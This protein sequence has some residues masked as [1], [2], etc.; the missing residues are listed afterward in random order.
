MRRPNRPLAL[1][2]CVA[3]DKPELSRMSV[4]VLRVVYARLSTLRSTRRDQ[5]VWVSCTSRTGLVQPP[6]ADFEEDPIRA[7]Y[8]VELC[9]LFEFLVKQLL[10]NVVLFCL[11]DGVVYYQRNE[12]I[13]DMGYVL[14]KLL[15]ISEDQD[16]Q[17]TVKILLTSPTRTNCVRKPFPDER[18]LSMALMAHVDTAPSATRLERQLRES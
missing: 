17:A 7:G 16:M 15:Q 1:D 10:K 5:T 11:L 18:I 3:R 12:F 4:L 9:R 14:V 8:I 13:D 2:D 6:A